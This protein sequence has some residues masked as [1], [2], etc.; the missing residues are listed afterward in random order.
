M[1]LATS[2]HCDRLITCTW[3]YPG[4]GFSLPARYNVEGGTVAMEVEEDGMREEEQLQE[5]EQGLQAP[6]DQALS[7][8]QEGYEAAIAERDAQIA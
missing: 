1:F 3:K 2:P 4:A 8:A 5:D 6:E 7:G